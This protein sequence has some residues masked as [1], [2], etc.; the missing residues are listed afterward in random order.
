MEGTNKVF[1][2]ELQTYISELKEVMRQKGYSDY[3]IYT[4]DKVWRNMLSYAMIRPNQEFT[5][6]FRQQFLHDI[7]AEAI[8]K[9]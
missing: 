6:N 9:Q 7:Y 3:Q 5:E 2:L 1:T 4:Y 8:E